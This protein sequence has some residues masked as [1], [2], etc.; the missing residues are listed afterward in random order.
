MS[1]AIWKQAY[2]FS[3]TKPKLYQE[4]IDMFG[5]NVLQPHIFINAATHSQLF[6]SFKHSQSQKFTC[7]L[8]ALDGM[9]KA[10]DDHVL[11]FIEELQLYGLFTVEG[12]T[13][14]M[15]KLSERAEDGIQSTP[16]Q[17]ILADRKQ[18]LV[19]ICAT[20]DKTI[21]GHISKYVRDCFGSDVHVIENAQK[22]EITINQMNN[23]SRDDTFDEL[24]TYISRRD[25]S[26]ADI[27]SL[28]KL[29]REREYRYTTPTF[30]ISVQTATE[31]LA[32]LKTGHTININAPIIIGNN[33]AINNNIGMTVAVK[34]NEARE[35]IRTNPPTCE[36]TG[37]YYIKYKSNA[38]HPLQV[39]KFAK[40]M[41]EQGYIQ[42]R[43]GSFNI[44]K[45]S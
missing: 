19:F 13:Q 34:T 42:S 4:M 1:A 32:I 38:K 30:D 9:T 25:K 7:A 12:Y 40:L 14:F 5:S 39:Q 6:A 31:L 45:K 21:L 28:P 27:L 33:N 18:K 15:K 26:I 16:R 43:L 2:E 22:A 29:I 44:W 17:V 37:D 3:E 10:G 20:D 11:I 23:R 36:K 24:F 8:D 41:T 35:W